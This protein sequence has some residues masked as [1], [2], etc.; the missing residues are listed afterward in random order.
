M[1]CGIKNLAVILAEIDTE[2]LVPFKSRTNGFKRLPE[3]PVNDYDISMLLDVN[4]TWEQIKSSVLSKKREL[5]RGVDFVDEYRGKQIPEGQ[6]SVTIRLALGAD[7]KTLTSEEIEACAA[8]V[9]K[10]LKKDLGAEV[11][12]K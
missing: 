1:A 8:A 5:L 12:G 2:L 9:I 6:K 3:Y 11:R 7:D 4:T 10:T